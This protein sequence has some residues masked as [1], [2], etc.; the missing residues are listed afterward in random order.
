LYEQRLELGKQELKEAT[1]SS[2][3]DM[4]PQEVSRSTE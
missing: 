2:M 3:D 1:N 4:P